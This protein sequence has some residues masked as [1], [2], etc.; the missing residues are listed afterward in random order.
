MPRTTYDDDLKSVVA[1]VVSG[2][3]LTLAFTLIALGISSFWVVFAIGFGAV[4]PASVKVA[5][6]YGEKQQ[7]TDET[8]DSKENA[9]EELKKKFINDEISEQE[10]E[11]RVEKLV[12]TGTVED[13]REYVERTKDEELELERN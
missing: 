10:F 1:T 11:K 2:L 4:L 3:T 6:Y 5:E 7:S 9:L 12:Q 8:Q 13:A